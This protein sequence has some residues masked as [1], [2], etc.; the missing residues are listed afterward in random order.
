MTGVAQGEALSSSGVFFCSSLKP[1]PKYRDLIRHPQAD[2]I[3]AGP[4]SFIRHSLCAF[5]S[6]TMDY[7]LQLRFG[8]QYV[9]ISNGSKVQIAALI[10]AI[11]CV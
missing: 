11:C 6:C 8:L 1:T 2:G 4:V 7:K 3:L 5:A 10:F 9:L